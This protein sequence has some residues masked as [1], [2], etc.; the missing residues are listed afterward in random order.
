MIYAFH[1]PARLCRCS[2]SL[3]F[4]APFRLGGLKRSDPVR[5]FPLRHG[6][7]AVGAAHRGFAIDVAQLK[8]GEHPVLGRLRINLMFWRGYFQL[9]GRDRPGVVPNTERNAAPNAGPLLYP[10]AAATRA[11][12][13]PSLSAASPSVSRNCRRH[14]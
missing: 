3:G 12:V 13:S 5:K 11:G 14:A 7:V 10:T 6:D 8:E 2:V 1:T 9:P 4:P